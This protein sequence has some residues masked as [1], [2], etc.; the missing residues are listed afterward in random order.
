MIGCLTVFLAAGE[1]D[2]KLI[3]DSEKDLQKAQIKLL[4]TKII[5]LENEKM[6]KLQKKYNFKLEI[7]K[8]SE[9]YLIVANPIRSKKLKEKLLVYGSKFYTDLFY[10]NNRIEKKIISNIHRRQKKSF[11]EKVGIRYEWI[12]ILLLSIIGLILSFYNRKKIVNIQG[13]QKDM[14]QKQD[15]IEKE[16]EGLEV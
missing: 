3:I 15:K 5:F 9:Y 6:K 14:D 8:I 2:Q 13:I 1:I 7:E 12:T 10:I 11:L 16:I 4:K